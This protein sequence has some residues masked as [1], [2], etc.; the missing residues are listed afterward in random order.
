V[1]CGA[2]AEA[3]Q[4]S[5]WQDFSVSLAAFKL[6]GGEMAVNWLSEFFG[7]TPSRS[8]RN[9]IASN[10]VRFDR[11]APGSLSQNRPELFDY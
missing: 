4:S 8:Q 9:L 3:P 2:A 5:H 6:A 10:N 11:L 1:N 7:N